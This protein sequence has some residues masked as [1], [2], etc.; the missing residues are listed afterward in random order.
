MLN[1]ADEALYA[2]KQAGRNRVKFA[3]PIKQ[4]RPPSKPSADTTGRPSLAPGKR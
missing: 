4:E 2:A 1:K 3:D